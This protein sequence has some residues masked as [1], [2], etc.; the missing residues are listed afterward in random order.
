MSFVPPSE[1][2]N[3]TVE[4]DLLEND[5]HFRRRGARFRVERGF[6]CTQ[7]V[8][9]GRQPRFVAIADDALRFAC[10]CERRASRLFA[11]ARGC[12][13]HERGTNLDFDSPLYALAF[14]GG[15]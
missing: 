1:A 9:H 13:L 2:A 6:R 10:L 7:D 5:V 3:R 11:C 14:R 4:R 8:G 15:A 12:Q